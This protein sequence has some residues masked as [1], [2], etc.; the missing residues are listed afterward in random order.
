MANRQLE[1]VP[2]NAHLAPVHGVAADFAQG[3][4]DTSLAGQ[5]EPVLEMFFGL[6]RRREEIHA[7]GD[8]DHALFALAVFMA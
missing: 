2:F 7:V 6:G 3:C 5:T 8:F 1:G 4:F